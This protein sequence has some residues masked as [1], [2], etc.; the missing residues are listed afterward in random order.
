MTLISESTRLTV[1]VRVW[2]AVFN[3]FLVI[4]LVAGTSVFLFLVNTLLA[5][6]SK[7]IY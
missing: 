3:T 6:T 4:G 7:V 1:V 2:Q 5:E